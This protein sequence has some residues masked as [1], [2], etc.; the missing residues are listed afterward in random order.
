MVVLQ[1]QENEHGSNPN[2]IVQARLAKGHRPGVSE[3]AA[4]IKTLKAAHSIDATPQRARQ[5]H[6]TAEVPITARIRRR[7]EMRPAPDQAIESDAASGARTT[8]PSEFPAQDSPVKPQMTFQERIAMERKR[9]DNPER[10]I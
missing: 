9:H 5:K 4:K 10:T 2:K 8:L 7:T 3:L 6:S 1:S